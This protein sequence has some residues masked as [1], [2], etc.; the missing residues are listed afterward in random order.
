V[1][2]MGQH[3]VDLGAQLACEV[4]TKLTAGAPG[5]PLT[6]LAHE[7]IEGAIWHTIYVHTTNRGASTLPELSDYL[8]YVVLAP[9]LGAKEATRIVTGERPPAIAAG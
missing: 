2:A 8:E 9:Y 5:A 4:A 3:A 1:F 7:G 6:K